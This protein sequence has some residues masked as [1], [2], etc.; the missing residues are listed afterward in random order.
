MTNSDDFAT[1][2]AVKVFD[3][4]VGTKEGR[5]VKIPRSPRCCKWGMNFQNPTGRTG[6]GRGKFIWIHEPEYLPLLDITFLR[7]NRG[8]LIKE[9]QVRTN[10]RRGQY[11]FPKQFAVCQSAY[12]FFYARMRKRKRRQIFMMKLKVWIVLMA[13]CLAVVRLWEYG[14]FLSTGNLCFGR[15]CIFRCGAARRTDRDL[16]AGIR[17]RIFH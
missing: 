9:K 5:R 3:L 4:I 1:L 2:I 7:G 13:L 10:D 6:W 14:R 17:Q 12:S 11:F 16:C 15:Q 8:C